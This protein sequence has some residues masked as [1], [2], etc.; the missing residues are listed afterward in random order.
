MSAPQAHEPTPTPTDAEPPLITGRYQTTMSEYL[1]HAPALN[2][3]TLFSNGFGAVALVLA[4]LSFPDPLAVAFEFALGL[5]LLS[6]Y[7]CVPFTWLALRSRTQQV[8]KPI[9]VVVDDAGLH[10]LQ[11]SVEI[12]APWEQ[13]TRLREDRDSFFLMARNPRAYVI[14]KRAFDPANLEAF[15]L[16][17]A[18]KGKLGQG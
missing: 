4:V 15:R 17:A 2:R 3:G 16:L 12:D 10:F 9:D 5:A 14:P 11:G 8:E 18:S 7:Y 6:G 1:R 13:T